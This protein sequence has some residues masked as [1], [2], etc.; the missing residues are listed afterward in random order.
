MVYMVLAFPLVAEW[1]HDICAHPVGGG[2]ESVPCYGAVKMWLLY[3]VALFAGFQEASHTVTLQVVALLSER[4]L[5][6][7][8]SDK[9]GKQCPLLY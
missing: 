2:E 3:Q 1:S 6:A 7:S 5:L 4:L 9:R 8:R